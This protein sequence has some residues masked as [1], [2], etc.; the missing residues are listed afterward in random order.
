LENADVAVEVVAVVVA[1]DAS[2]DGPC[3]RGCLELNG[4]DD[5][6]ELVVFDGGLTEGCQGG[7]VIATVEVVLHL[8]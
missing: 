3:W 4:G 2:L 8:C 1:D 6:L 5:D 7:E